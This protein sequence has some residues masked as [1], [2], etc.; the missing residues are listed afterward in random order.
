MSTN[1]ELDNF[2]KSMSKLQIINL[3][4]EYGQVNYLDYEK[5][6]GKIVLFCFTYRKWILLDK[7]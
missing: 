6:S 4:S 2:P 5:G 3:F 1:L 7:L